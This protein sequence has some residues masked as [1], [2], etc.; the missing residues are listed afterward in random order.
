LLGEFPEATYT[1]TVL[2][3]IGTGERTFGSIANKAGAGSPI[4]SGTLSPILANLTAKRVI[5][6]DIP[7]SGK[8]DNKNKRYRVA[9]PYLRF[10]L[11]FLQRGIA[12][13]ERGRG[14]LV[15]RRI[16]RSWASWRGRAVEPVIRESLAMMLPADEWP[17]TEAIG[18]WWNRQNNPEIDLIGADRSPVA[19][20]I[21][22]VGS[23]KWLEDQ[24]FS[25][26]DYDCLARDRFSVPGSDHQ[27][28]LV[29]V[30]RS[31]V[32]DALPLAQVWG[33]DDL[34]D[35]WRRTAG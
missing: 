14:D 2:E 3:S 27:T 13:S 19:N 7:L 9:D 30:T 22:F 16:E 23:I 32:V 29:A 10:W 1:R 5:A 35:A 31:G 17:E 28:P 34:V 12:E 24:P 18:G 25:R 26:P 15:H 6:V 20:R 4:P 21:H 8:P 33:P 11:A